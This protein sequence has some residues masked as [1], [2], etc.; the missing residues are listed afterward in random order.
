MYVD[1]L[2]QVGQ[3]V[4]TDNFY[5]FPGGKGSNQAISAAKFG[6]K[7]RFFGRIGTEPGSL[8]MTGL[9]ERAGID[10][11]HMLQSPHATV[12]MCVILVEKSTGKNMIV[13]NPAATLLL[14]P[15]DI[16]AHPE[17]FFRG[18]LFALTMEFKRETVYAAIRA[19]HAAGME[20][21]LDPLAIP[22]GEFPAD[23]PPMVDIIKPNETEASALTGIEVRDVPSAKRAA[24][25][26]REMGFGTPIL[27]L[28]EQGIL[29]LRGDTFLEIPRHAVNAVDTTAAGDVLIGSFLAA[30]A[31]GGDFAGA[32]R[33]AN[34]A[35]ALST[36]KM[37]A[38]TSIPTPEEAAALLERAR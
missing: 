16:E 29:A 21:M 10:M 36:T 6:A 22:G 3:S 11:S 35:A 5:R 31:A 34:A 25:A 2:P 23:I 26:L 28:G 24:R 38:Q 17:V 7:A 19:A 15:A 14:A 12:G 13:F 1:A 32:L 9:L 33:T 27:S 8:E 37:G 18:G 20:I 30:Y 4:M